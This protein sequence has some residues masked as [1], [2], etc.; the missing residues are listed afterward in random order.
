MGEWVGDRH[1]DDTKEEEE[2]ERTFGTDLT[3]MLHIEDLKNCLP[4]DEDLEQ[5]LAALRCRLFE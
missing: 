2:E 3:N 4:D 5:N 1:P